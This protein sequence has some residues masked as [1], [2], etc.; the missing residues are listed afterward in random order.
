MLPFIN[1]LSGRSITQ[2]R[3]Q[4]I[5]YW[6]RI[7]GLEYFK[8]LLALRSMQQH[9]T[10]NQSEGNNNKESSTTLQH[11]Q[12]KLTLMSFIWKFQIERIV[13]RLFL[14]FCARKMCSKFSKKLNLKRGRW[15]QSTLS[16]NWTWFASHYASRRHRFVWYNNY[17]AGTQKLTIWSII[18]WKSVPAWLPRQGWVGQR[19]ETAALTARDRQPAFLPR[20]HN[21]AEK[22]IK[23]IMDI[24]TKRNRQNQI[25]S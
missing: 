11:K 21:N 24:C 9:I 2:P 20:A 13:H 14:S 5:N 7:K 4:F 22:R 8:K 3:M 23:Q 6:V 19:V 17:S 12:L 25:Y 1:L 15:K 16:A 18:R 10:F